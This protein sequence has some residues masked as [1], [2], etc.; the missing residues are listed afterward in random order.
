MT[1]SGSTA[2]QLKRAYAHIKAGDNKSAI[3]IIRPILQQD[4]DNAAAWWLL[5]NATDNPT[6]QEKALEHVLRIKP[7]EVKAQQMLT[8]LRSGNGVPATIPAPTRQPEP[9]PVASTDYDED[10]FDDDPFADDPFADDAQ[11]SINNLG[12]DINELIDQFSEE[13]DQ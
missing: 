3:G 13:D 8:T 6:H 4:K 7:G 5:A 11:F 9:E 12:K 1:M 10:D 2:D